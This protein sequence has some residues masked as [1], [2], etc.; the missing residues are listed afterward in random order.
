MLNYR[1]ISIGTLS[2]NPLWNEPP[3]L[4]TAHATTTLIRADDKAIL[5]DPAL[6]APALAAHLHEHSGLQSSQITDIFLT[7]FRPAHRAAKHDKNNCQH[8]RNTTHNRS[9]PDFNTSDYLA[10]C[11]FNCDR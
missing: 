4:R 2:S 10:Y 3:A 5:V 8:T 7:N 1:S 9:L 11:V 6:P